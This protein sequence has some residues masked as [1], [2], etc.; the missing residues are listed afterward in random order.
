MRAVVFDFDGV[1]A[2]T[3]AL[4]LRVFQEV[5]HERGWM[6][7][8][9]AYFD[10][11]LGFDDRDLVAAF[12]EDGKLTVT[13]SEIR[14][15][16]ND[17]VRRYERRLSEGGVI[18]ATAAPAI[19]RLGA[20]YSLAIASGSLGAE[21]TAILRPAGLDTAFQ[22]IVGA[23]SV[24]RSKPAADPYVAAVERLGVPPASAVAIEDSRWGLTSA[25][26]AGLRTIGI[27]TSYAAGAL[28]EA[29]AIVTSLDEVT[30][31]L[32][33]RLLG[34]PAFGTGRADRV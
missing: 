16:V 1:L 20:R 34:A 12:V 30:I 7:D 5:F 27:T 22:V 25:R 8:R 13:A 19:A 29:D 11:Y 14:T 31:D 18:F 26:A 33:E 28:A 6:L 15:L 32:V 9:T 3:E 2:D 4:H 10:R 24:A 21:I 17:K 23:D